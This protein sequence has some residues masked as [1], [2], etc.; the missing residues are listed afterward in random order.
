M[1]VR[2][3]GFAG[4]RQTNC[5]CSSRGRQR[6]VVPVEELYKGPCWRVR[7][8]PDERAQQ[9]HDGGSSAGS[10]DSQLGRR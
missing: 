8:T 9:Q 3:G 6:F 5:S 4:F 2:E 1:F 10:E 7:G